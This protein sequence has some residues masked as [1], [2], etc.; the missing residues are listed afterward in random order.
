[1]ITDKIIKPNENRFWEWTPKNGYEI[2]KCN[3]ASRVI[4]DEAAN[5]CLAEEE[6][7]S[8]EE[9][10]KEQSKEEKEQQKEE[11]SKEKEE[12]Q[13]K[14][15]EKKK[16]TAYQDMK[17]NRTRKQTEFKENVAKIIESLKNKIDKM[18]DK[19]LC[20]P[21][22]N[23]VDTELEKGKGTK[24]QTITDIRTYIRKH[25]CL[26]KN[27]IAEYVLLCPKNKS[28]TA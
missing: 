6:E 9:E 15:K 18:G 1:V 17:N 28:K 27:H 13:K 2:K 4:Y 23:F 24:I 26:C 25:P 14:G 20:K 7:E 16:E 21:C 11:E 5:K 22:D 12:A 19:A 10:S 8:K 3:G